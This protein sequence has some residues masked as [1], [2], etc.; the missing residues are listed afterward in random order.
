MFRQQAPGL[1]A[2]QGLLLAPDKRIGV[3]IVDRPASVP[4]TKISGAE[5][6]PNVAYSDA[7]ESSD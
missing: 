2:V 3:Y 6:D 7:R 1:A 4:A 5:Y